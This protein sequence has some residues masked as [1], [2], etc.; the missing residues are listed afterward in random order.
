MVQWLA[1]L[2]ASTAGGRGSIPVREQRFLCLTTQQKKKKKKLRHTTQNLQL[3]TTE[4]LPV[5]PGPKTLLR[6]TATL[7]ISNVL[8]LGIQANLS[9]QN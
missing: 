7:I 1:G 2:H 8:Y 5:K 6:I 3:D 9:I 4:Q